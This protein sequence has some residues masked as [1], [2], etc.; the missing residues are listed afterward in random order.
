MTP[1]TREEFRECAAEVSSPHQRAMG[2]HD[3]FGSRGGGGQGPETG[4]NFTAST[5]SD[6]A[7]ESSCDHKDTNTS[8]SGV[9]E[10][11]SNIYRPSRKGYTVAHTRKRARIDLLQ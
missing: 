5:T 11:I 4:N 9:V 6:I 3:R 10:K 8:G 1:K 2:I 7:N